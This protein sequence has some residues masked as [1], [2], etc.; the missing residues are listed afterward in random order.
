M[1]FYPQRFIRDFVRSCLRFYDRFC[2]HYPRLAQLLRFG[3]SGGASAVL[4][5][6]VLAFLW[7]V[8]GLHYLTATVIAVLCGTTL[9]FFLQKLWSFQNSSKGAAHTSRQFLIFAINAAFNLAANT[10]LMA[11]FVEKVALQP[12]LAQA[13]CIVILMFWNFVV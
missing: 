11:F 8:A 10:A 9:N 3:F 4:Q 13:F 7:H 12:V 2:T 1:D 6:S 5:L